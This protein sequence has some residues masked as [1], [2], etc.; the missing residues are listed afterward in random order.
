MLQSSYYGMVN[1]ETPYKK[2]HARLEISSR[3]LVELDKTHLNLN[4]QVCL[5]D[6]F[7][8]KFDI[9]RPLIAFYKAYSKQLLL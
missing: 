7:L 1:C 6:H 9:H 8:N 4:S 3:E 2:E 5:G